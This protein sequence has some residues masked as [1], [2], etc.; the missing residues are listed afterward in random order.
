VKVFLQIV[1]IFLVYTIAA[2]TASAIKPGPGAT[3]VPDEIFFS[4][5]EEAQPNKEILIAF[6]AAENLQLEG[7]L[8][9]ALS[10]YEK[11]LGKYPNT[12]LKDEILMN[13]AWCYTQLGD[14]D[15]AIKSYLKIVSSNPNS[16]EASQAVSL[17]IN[18][19][20]QRY[21]F[22]EV[23]AISR[24]IAQQFPGT[25][26]A[27]MAMYRI[28]NS[29]YSQGKSQEAIKEFE[30][31]ISQFPKSTM[32][33]TAISRLISL[34]IGANMF[35]EAE[36]KL[37]DNLA[38]NPNDTYLLRQM[39][40][41][42]QKQGKYDEALALYQRILKIQ[43]N[44]V[45]T[46]EQIGELYAE[47]GD[48]ERAI[49]EWSKI[50]ETTPGE[51]YRHQTLAYILKSHGFYDQAAAEYRK[52]IE[53]QPQNSYLYTQLAEVYIVKKQF[54]EAVSVYLNALTGLPVSNNPYRSDLVESMMELCDLEGLYDKVVAELKRRLLQSPDNVSAVLT[55]A[56]V[57]FRKGDFD[58]SLQQLKIVASLQ[59]DRGQFLL[60]YAQKLE[61]EKYFNHSIKFYQT[62]LDLFPDSELTLRALMHIGQLESE[63]GQP[64]SAIEH[65][66]KLVSQANNLRT[67]D[68]SSM[69]L[70]AL[71]AI[72]DIYLNQVHDAQ[73]ALS[74]YM[75]AK[76]WARSA[77]SIFDDP[78]I[79]AQIIDLE[80]KI[81]EC[82]CLMG[83]YDTVEN[84]LN[85]ISDRSRA[86]TA[87]IARLR[88]D[89]YFNNGDFDS[90]LTS[91]QEAIQGS[92]NEGYVNDVLD[93]IA[94]IKEHSSQELLKTYAQVERLKSLG[95]YDEALVICLSSVKKYAGNNLIDRVKLEAGDLLSLQTRDR[96][97][98]SA[99]EE[100]IQ[101]QS[102]LAPEAQLRI[103][104][105]YWQ[106][107]NDPV[108]AI[109]SYTTL[110]EKYPDSVLVVDAR[111]QIRRLASEKIPIGD[112]PH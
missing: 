99:Y 40:L 52:A 36:R 9:E 92:L 50:T 63:L 4:D 34:Y 107:L 51:Y 13:M 46:Y 100:L 77:E 6:R 17:M 66:Q 112:L 88:G 84:L 104:E 68:A 87:R 82:Y 61:R 101:S 97:A 62:L 14:D 69:R 25:E 72:G 11:I 45:D 59:P 20:N 55:L 39:G 85:S 54:D 109:E 35:A 44:D 43:P 12:D 108:H 70:A 48:K 49:A 83:Q 3:T 74:T 81:G 76:V 58:N 33:S 53:L 65:L 60:N 111:K 89:C 56:E 102:P 30:N 64:Q 67:P 105:T 41:V 24:Q 31:F 98:I 80:L 22:D 86:T 1:S 7:K 90:A 95:K 73:A 18:L 5:T 103:A 8:Q 28:A 29:F 78:G 23:I 16:M 79:G 37:M 93:K 91:Y 94:L 10:A 2:T 19:Y 38:Q 21:R 110:I 75:E 96:E 15:S 26:V 106:K 71:T 47:K 57:Y 27:A 42:Y 32:R